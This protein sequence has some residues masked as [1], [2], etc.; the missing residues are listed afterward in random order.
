[1]NVLMTCRCACA[2][3]RA[4]IETR[5]VLAPWKQHPAAPISLSQSPCISCYDGT[6]IYEHPGDYLR[7]YFLLPT[8]LEFRGTL[9]PITT[10]T[11]KMPGAQPRGGKPWALPPCFIRSQTTRLHKFHRPVNLHSLAADC[12][13][14]GLR[15]QTDD[16]RVLESSFWLLASLATSMAACPL[17][18]TR[19]SHVR[20]RKS[21]RGWSTMQ[22]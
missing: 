15:R 12:K 10:E 22:T 5:L 4:I 6:S 17:F 14:W 13:V 18:R 11:T 9:Q 16:G 8:G 7:L 3:D 19:M 1:M 20:G 2:E 21:P